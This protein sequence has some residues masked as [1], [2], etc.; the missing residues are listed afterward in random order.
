MSTLS[1][2]SEALHSLPPARVCRVIALDLVDNPL[3]LEGIALWR[4]LAGDNPYP[5]RS[6]ITARV[7]KPLLRNVSLLK[8][9]D[10]GQDYEHRI[11]GDAFVMAH[12]RSCQ[13]MLWSETV[14]L[15]AGFRD[16]IKPIYDG[17]VRNGEPIAT[18]GW[19]ER[20][21]GSTGHVYC[22]YVYLPLGS[23]ETGVDHILIF[24][25]YLKR[26]GIGQNDPAITGSFAG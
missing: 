6:D 25:V 11:V 17:V 21:A 5:A 15:F 4:S 3:L 16:F 24:A 9:V 22:E 7:L 26:D 10:G 19:I 8:V 18:R 13:G 23:A 14:K 1:D 20:G 2:K 12:G